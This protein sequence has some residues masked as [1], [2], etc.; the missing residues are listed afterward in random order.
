MIDPGTTIGPVRLVSANL[1]RATSFYEGVLGMRGQQLP[2]GGYAL[3]VGAEALIILDE[4]S[5]A[6]ARPARSS[7]LYHAAILVPS[8]SDLARVLLRLNELS[9]PLS[10]ASD[11]RVSEAL[12]LNDPDGNGIEIYAD[13]PRA[14]WPRSG[15]EVR[16]SVDPLDFTD[17]LAT[18]TPPLSA[19]A[20]LPA[21]T[22]LGHIHLQ[23]NDLRAAEAFYVGVLGFEVMQRFGGSALFLAAGGYHHHLGLNTWASLGAPSTPSETIG[24]RYFSL[25]LP[26]ED[27]L[28]LIA[29][30]VRTAG[31]SLEAT[32][33]GLLLRDPAQNG[34]MLSTN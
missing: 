31:L 17:L 34:L 2:A 4:L 26:N 20:G 8:R 15:Q 33:E 18:L 24:L 30:R 16:M 19:W 22:T 3:S 32:A 14:V 28:D 7:G 27:A 5:T 12:Y 10:G 1:P 13:R 23:V 11:H 29:S 25:R 6:R 21:N 9:Y